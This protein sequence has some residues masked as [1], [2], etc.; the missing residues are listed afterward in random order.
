MEKSQL[1]RLAAIDELDLVLAA[2][3]GS[4]R[5]NDYEAPKKALALRDLFL[6]LGFSKCL[7]HYNFVPFRIFDKDYDQDAKCL[8]EGC[9]HEYNRHF[10]WSAGYFPGCKYCSCRTFTPISEAADDDSSSPDPQGAEDPP[11]SVFAGDGDE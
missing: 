9:G 3:L 1:D 11:V 2:Y 7:A 8:R 5:Y 4:D 6:R 10:D